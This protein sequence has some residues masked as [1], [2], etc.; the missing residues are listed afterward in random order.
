MAVPEDEG[1]EGKTFSEKFSA[2]LAARK[3]TAGKG[4]ETAT[5]GKAGCEEAVMS[6]EDAVSYERAIEKF[7]ARRDDEAETLFR[8]LKERYPRD[9][10]VLWH[11][12]EVLFRG[13]RYA[14]GAALL[15]GKQEPMPPQLPPPQ[16]SP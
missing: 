13:E 10:G 9:C 16:E 11:L 8:E 4:E 14:E 12:S 7:R 15:E 3:G 6:G 1:L 2:W 5:S